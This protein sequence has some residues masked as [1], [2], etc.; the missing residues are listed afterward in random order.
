[1]V[2]FYICKEFFALLEFPCYIRMMVCKYLEAPSTPRVKEIDF[3]LLKIWLMIEG[4]FK[5]F[6]ERSER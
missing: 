3:Q 4:I 2:K 6:Y 5:T 1:M